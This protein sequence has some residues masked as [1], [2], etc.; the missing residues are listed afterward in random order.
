VPE[1]IRKAGVS[2]R[3]S[4]IKVS[5]SGTTIPHEIS[6]KF[7]AA[8]VLLKPAS[9]GTG[10]I[11]GGGVRA[12]VE[13]AGIKDVLTKSLGSSSPVNVCKATVLALSSL[14]KPEEAVAR[15]KTEPQLEETE[16]NG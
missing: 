5:M 10:A 13:A 7:R 2:A 8:R 1:A 3:K 4:L 16:G 15:R 11:A 6:A 9:P 14:R 12:V